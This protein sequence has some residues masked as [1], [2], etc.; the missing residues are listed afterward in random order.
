[1]MNVFHFTK[2]VIPL[3][4]FFFFPKCTQNNNKKITFQAMLGVVRLI[5]TIVS[6]MHV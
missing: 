6:V 2:G 3:E 4:S 1:M 5:R